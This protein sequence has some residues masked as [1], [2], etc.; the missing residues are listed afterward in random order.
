MQL[1][2]ITI[3]LRPRPARQALDLGF[4]LLHA[5][6]AT[7]YKTWLALWLPLAAIAAALT[8]ALPD[9]AALWILLPWWLKP[10]LERAPL[11]VLSKTSR[12]ARPCGRGPDRWAAAGYG[13]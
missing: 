7:V 11:Y 9:E 5:R 2:R 1:D 10:L 3:A 4:A 8:V 6:A 12:G 13:C